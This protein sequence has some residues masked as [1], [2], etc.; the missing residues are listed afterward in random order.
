M[1][2]GSRASRKGTSPSVD[3]NN[4]NIPQRICSSGAGRPSPNGIP[5]T[6]TATACR[7]LTCK[8]LMKYCPNTNNW[9]AA[10]WLD[11]ERE[12]EEEGPSWDNAS[13]FFFFFFFFWCPLALRD[14]RCNWTG[15][16]WIFGSGWSASEGSDKR[17]GI[18]GRQRLQI[19]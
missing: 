13:T 12:R 8:D 6:K 18:G 11:R 4:T 3:W 17:N 2:K 1:S 5:Q 19:S 10:R 14:G 9:H 15:R 7:C 16:K